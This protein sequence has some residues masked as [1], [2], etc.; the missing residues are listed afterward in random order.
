MYHEVTPF[1]EL[2]ALILIYSVLAETR[3]VHGAISILAPQVPWRK[4]RFASDVRCKLRHRYVKLRLWAIIVGVG[5]TICS[6]ATAESDLSEVAPLVISITRQLE[7]SFYLPASIDVVDS[8]QI[9]EGQPR[10]NLSET[11]QQ[12]PGIVAQNRHNFARDEQISS[13][14][15]G[16]RAQFGVRGVRLIADDIP[17]TM[18][19][20]QGQTGM[21][22]LNSA[23]RIEVMRGP[24]SAI[25]GNSSGGVIQV[26]TEDGPKIPTAEV[27]IEVGS[28]DTSRIGSKFGG[29]SG[30]L[31]YLLSASQLKTSGYRQHSA[32]IRRL[33]NTKLK[34]KVSSAS[35]FSI[36]V[37]ALH[38][39]DS[40]DPLGLTKVQAEEDPQQAVPAAFL[41]NTRKTVEHHQVGVAYERRLGNDHTIYANGYLGG[42]DVTQFL[43]FTGSYGLSSGGVVDLDRG[44]GG[45]ELRW[46]GNSILGGT[47]FTWTVGIEN[48]RQDEQRKGY[49]N[50][51]GEIGE[52]RRDE[53]NTVSNIDEYFQ[54]KCQVTQKWNINAGLR[55]SR[56][57]FKSD[58]F[59]VTQTNPD[60]SGSVTYTSNNPVAGVVYRA[61]PR[62]NLYSSYGRGFETP[63]FTELAYRPD[64][65]SGLNFDLQPSTSDNFEL[66]AKVLIGTTGRIYLAAFH[67][68]TRNEIIV[69]DSV[70]GRTSYRNAESTRRVGMEVEANAELG[71]GFSYNFSYSYIDAVFKD[72]GASAG[73]QLPGVP[74]TMAYAELMWRHYPTGLY[75][76][77]NILWRDKMY[78]DDTNSE[79]ADSY[80]VANY[81]IGIS[82]SVGFW[83]YKAFIRID[84]IF[85]EAYV[86]SIIVGDR[87]GRYYE[88]A[89]E[90]S[91]LVGASVGYIF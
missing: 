7:S 52:L 60:D 49:V 26:F 63:T 50:D 78:V 41:F 24:Y 82:D 54:A 32:A 55:H 38:D 51:F 33:F 39:P 28:F 27:D 83:F 67:V 81:R 5:V 31:N 17:L 46:H 9:Q 59:F 30:D 15:F 19:D 3:S 21:I 8:E 53:D 84:N 34:Y 10:I 57:V 56:V 72:D 23:Q 74:R 2:T 79:Y 43:P 37:S 6:N 64:G 86:G 91:Y 13:R 12:M 11:L 47:P 42:R 48:D 69:A 89:P 85:D 45:A 14:G 16:A 75:S 36:V 29:Q 77:L 76:A 90:R 87:N 61:T 22:D 65:T 58:D 80:T 44:F 66:G 4:I 35:D 25:Y 71:S 40:Q 88:P 70:N 62:L 73:N 20:G 1:L 68:D 18:P